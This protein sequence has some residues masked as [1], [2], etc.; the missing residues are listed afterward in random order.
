M[1]DSLKFYTSDNIRNIYFVMKNIFLVISFMAPLIYCEEISDENN[2]NYTEFSQQKEDNVNLAI[3]RLEGLE[4]PIE[5][6]ETAGP[7]SS[8]K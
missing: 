8:A 7:S 3:E 4:T 1:A 6:H 5:V 2:G